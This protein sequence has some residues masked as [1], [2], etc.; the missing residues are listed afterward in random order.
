MEPKNEVTIDKNWHS[1][2][3]RIKLNHQSL[4]NLSK[5][6]E[7]I[8]QEELDKISE[9]IRHNINQAACDIIN[10]I[11]N[12]SKL[13]QGDV[14]PQILSHNKIP[15]PHKRRKRKNKIWFDHELQTLKDMTKNYLTKNTSFLKIYI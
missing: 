9:K 4:C 13:V 12:A 11:E 5:S 15:F 3:K 1:L 10:V 2:P 7:S 8:G 6:L 14:P